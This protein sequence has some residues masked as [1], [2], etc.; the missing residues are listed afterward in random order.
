MRT[1][2]SLALAF[3][4]L[5]PTALADARIDKALAAFRAGEYEK[6]VTLAGEVPGGAPEEA[7]ALYLVGRARLAL[8]DPAKA[9]S[10]FEKLLALRPASVPGRVGLANALEARGK[11]DEALVHLRKAVETDAKD[12]DARRALGEHLLRKDQVA[13]ARKQI[14]EAYELDAKDP[15]VAR[16]WVDCLL[17][18]DEVKVAQRVADAFAKARPKSPVGPFLQGLCLD[19]DGKDKGAIEA[20]EKALELDD[21]FIDAHKNLA[22]LCHAKNPTY[23]DME[24]TKKAL[25]HYERYFALGGEDK[26]LEQLYKTVKSFLDQYMK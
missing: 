24:R 10:A 25:V 17:R 22:I 5:A 11:D 13:E 20:Y 26:E 18:G 9:Q 23:Q 8:G 14:S 15:F 12:V 6:V 7:Q 19:R 3:V 16:A 4:L 2:T 1:L 21:T